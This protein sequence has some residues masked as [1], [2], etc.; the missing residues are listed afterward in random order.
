MY[1]ELQ[2]CVLAAEGQNLHLSALISLVSFLNAHDWSECTCLVRN[3]LTMQVEF[4][5]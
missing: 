2:A 4:V 1:V 5:V 3:E